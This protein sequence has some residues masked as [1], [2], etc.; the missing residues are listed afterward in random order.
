MNNLKYNNLIEEKE[1]KIKN[2]SSKITRLNNILYTNTI[3]SH[4]DHIEKDNCLVEYVD[5]KEFK[6]YVNNFENIEKNIDSDDKFNDVI[7]DILSF[8]RNYRYQIPK[9]PLPFGHFIFQR[10]PIDDISKKIEGLKYSF[11]N[12][13]ENILKLFL[14]LKKLIEL[15]DNPILKKILIFYPQGLLYFQTGSRFKEVKKYIEEITNGNIT[16]VSGRDLKNKIIEEKLCI[17]GYPSWIKRDLHIFEAPKFKKL[18]CITFGF[19]KST[20]NDT[21]KLIKTLGKKNI[22]SIPKISAYQNLFQKIFTTQEDSDTDIESFEIE[23][24]RNKSSKFTQNDIDYQNSLNA[25]MFVFSDNRIAY[26]TNESG[27]DESQRTIEIDYQNKPSISKKNIDDFKRGDIVVLRIGSSKDLMIEIAD[28]KILKSDK[29]RNSQIKWKTALEHQLRKRH[30]DKNLLAKDLKKIGINHANTVN[31]NSWL[32]ENNI[33]LG[34][35]DL[36][37]KLLNFLEFSEVESKNVLDDMHR[38]HSSHL[39]ANK[40]ITNELTKI[41]KNSDLNDLFKYGS[42]E[43][44]I[45]DTGAKMGL[46]V[47]QAIDDKNVRMPRRFLDRILDKSD[48][49]G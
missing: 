49:Y 44:E 16:V 17:I 9:T 31:I 42:Q 38:I 33:K 37:L 20:N 36:F 48:F 7:H 1:A 15:N 10:E 13:Y 46:F 2:N 41:I 5:S 23:Y 12:Y 40:F 29:E 14:D 4:F 28:N 43:F 45:G 24:F 3:Y 39:Q 8:F 6:I 18:Y 11:P 19:L 35:D 30:L 21:P 27:V 26:M 47:V 34:E 32:S 22:Y 25:K